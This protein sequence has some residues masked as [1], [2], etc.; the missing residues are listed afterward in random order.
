MRW[1]P[2]RRILRGRPPRPCRLCSLLRAPFVL[3]GVLSR[4]TVLQ[5]AYDLRIANT[6]ALGVRLRLCLPVLRWTVRENIG[7]R[8]CVDPQS[9]QHAVIEMTDRV[10]LRVQRNILFS[11]N[12]PL[13]L[14]MGAQKRSNQTMHG[15]HARAH[16]ACV[17]PR[18]GASDH[19][20]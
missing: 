8:L 20:K 1:A 18:L 14:S 12:K 17:C 11:I 4:A 2:L 6:G 3:C 9:S 13:R 15:A 19:L 5:E 10:F 16:D 7:V